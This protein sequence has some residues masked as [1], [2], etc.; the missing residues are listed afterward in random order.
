M[1]IIYLF[2]GGNQALPRKSNGARLGAAFEKEADVK[3]LTHVAI[4]IMLLI[5]GTVEASAQKKTTELEKQLTALR[6][7]F[8]IHK[9]T[10]YESANGAKEPQL[11]IT[12]KDSANH[13]VTVTLRASSMDVVGDL[14]ST[15]DGPENV[16]DDQPDPIDTISFSFTP[17]LIDLTTLGLVN[18]PTKFITMN[19]KAVKA[20][21]HC[22]EENVTKYIP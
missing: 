19:H 10:D 6:G 21:I 4:V 7:P 1:S 18:L 16:G 13:F 9:V 2:R 5:P 8:E 17:E 15:V 12:Y 3:L 20:E 11:S 14:G 22:T